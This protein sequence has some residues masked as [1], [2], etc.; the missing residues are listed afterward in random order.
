MQFSITKQ[1]FQRGL[2]AVSR[3]ASGKMPLPVLNNILMKAEPGKLTLSATDLELGIS[4]TL[5]AKVDKPGNFTVPARLLAEFI[6]NSNDTTFEGEVVDNA[7]LNLK[8]DHS[9]VRIRGIDASEFPGLPFVDQPPT[10]HVLAKELK[11]AIDTTLFATA[12]DD[13][14]PALSG[15]FIYT[16]EQVL[17]VV[18]TDSYRLAEKQLK[19]AAKAANECSVIVPKKTL[20]DVSRLLTDEAGDISVFVGD[21]QI[22]FEINSTR[23]V[24]RTIEGNYPPYQ[25]I[26]PNGYQ[27]RVTANHSELQA[28]LKT[29]NLF[30]RDAGNMVKLKI[31]P[32]KGMLVESVADQRGDASS[33]M[34][35]IVEGEEL[36]IPFNVKYLLEA[37]NVI[38]AENIF[39]ECNGP[40]KAMVIKPAN[41]KEYLSLVMPL[42]LD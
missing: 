34:T 1:N 5:P 33:Q 20:L 37:V 13:T 4:I 16:K 10:F 25:A 26:I 36:S 21:N 7:T 35:A 28:S 31:T 3:L 14:R 27:T 15:C 17:Y 19:L 6:Q 40:E 11:Q 30:A 38:Q 39:I 2:N 12:V 18:A 24:S 23:V 8:S 29:V 41:S 22:Q 9:G 42:K 32:G